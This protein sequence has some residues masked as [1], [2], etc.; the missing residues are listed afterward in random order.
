MAIPQSTKIARW[1]KSSQ[2]L[3]P[4][5][6]WENVSSL[7]LWKQEESTAFKVE[8]EWLCL[9]L[10]LSEFGCSNHSCSYYAEQ[11]FD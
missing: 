4:Q 11:L 5:K 3:T 7:H 1:G 6:R 2:T 10:V 8:E 9:I